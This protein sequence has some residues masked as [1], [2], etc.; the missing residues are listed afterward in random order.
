MMTSSLALRKR[1][2][3]TGWGEQFQRDSH[4]RKK[5]GK[6]GAGLLGALYIPKEALVHTLFLGS[7]VQHRL[8]SVQYLSPTSKIS[9]S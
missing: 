1:T 3:R 8:Y 2:G 9:L 4:P 5:P 6:T 7:A